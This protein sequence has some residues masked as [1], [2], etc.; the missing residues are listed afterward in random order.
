MRVIRFNLDT[1]QRFKL[2]Y[3]AAI[4]AG[5]ASFEFEGNEFLV[6]YAA[7]LIAFLTP[8][9]ALCGLN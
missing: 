4:A 3:N 6:A 2:A 5:L 9:F 7:H 1:F 8:K